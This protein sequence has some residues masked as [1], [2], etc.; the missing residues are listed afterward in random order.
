MSRNILPSALNY[1]ANTSRVRIAHLVILELPS[2]TEEQPVYDYLTDY[3]TEVKHNNHVYAPDRVVKVG[4]VR[5]GLK[6]TNYK[7][8]VSIAGEYQDELNRA[9]NEN[10]ESSFVGKT[11]RVLRAYLDDEGKVIPFD[12][13]TLGP[14]EYFFGNVSDIAIADGVV[15]GSSTVTWQCAGKFEDFNL[16]NG[17]L[18]DDASH[19]GLETVPGTSELAP[20]TGA[21]KPEYMLD[22]GFQHANQTISLLSTYTT[23]EIRYKMK[24]SFFGL[25]SKLQEVEVQVEKELEL[26]VDLEAKYLPF[27][28][29]VRR[30]PGMPIFIDNLAHDPAKLIIVYSIA[31]GPAS[32]LNLFIGGESAICVD[33]AQQETDMCLGSQA[34]GDTLS[35]FLRQDSGY[36]N[37]N[38]SYSPSL[39]ETERQVAVA[40]MPTVS[41]IFPTSNTTP[42]SKGI[43]RSGTKFTITNSTGVKKFTYYTG[44]P[45]QLAD[46][47]MVSIAANRAF[48]RQRKENLGPEYWDASSKLLDTAYLI[49]E[50][51]ISEG[52]QEIPELEMVIESH[53]TDGNNPVISLNPADHLQ[54]YLASKAFGGGLSPSE[55][56]FAS[57]DY[58][59]SVLGSELKSYDKNWNK[60]WRYLGWQSLEDHTPTLLECNSYISTEDT[61]TKN[62]ESFLAQMDATLNQ[63]GGKYHLSIEDG[64]DPIADILIEEVIGSV[65]VKD[66]SGKDK[67]NSIS[68]NLIDPALN[69]SANKLVFFDSEYLEQDK[70]VQ[71]KGTVSFNHITN[72]YVARNWAR[73]Q[74]DRSRYSREVTI[75]TYH[76]YTY[77]YP[78]AN[79]TFTYPRFGWDKKKLRVK[80]TTLKADGTIGL[81][82]VDTDASIYEDIVDT[83]LPDNP[84]VGTGIVPPQN[85]QFI[86]TSDENFDIKAEDNV[87]GFL[88]WSP[89]AGSSI[90]RYEVEDW[91]RPDHYEYNVVVPYNKIVYHKTSG[92]PFIFQEITDINLGTGYTFRVRTLDRSGKYSKYS[93]LD[94]TFSNNDLPGSYSKVTNFIA[95]NISDTG[96]YSGDTVY[97]Q[98]DKHPSPEITHYHLELLD[99]ASLGVF[100]IL[101]EEVSFTFDIQKNMSL[102]ANNN[103]GL[104]GAYRDYTARIRAVAI[105]GESDWQYL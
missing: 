81:T 92:E 61:V 11:V 88:L 5:Q 40:S 29:G 37:L 82:L 75:T 6:L 86:T 101:S 80:G 7:L 20:G 46:P 105:N 42:A 35:K 38:S 68:A 99:G 31:E 43:S 24:S 57:F 10:K 100:T 87:Y 71:K 63:L 47:T 32:L 51:Q 62:V 44:S 66:V 33:E 98:W 59:R 83:K 52:E 27:V 67:W 2:S 23:K 17:R 45:G 18:T 94:K 79:V 104:V 34:N 78:N 28:R 48:F 26:G 64:A 58:V 54:E 85:L 39:R 95:T 65:G 14:M 3:A 103:T 73:R 19:R 89:Y 16:V 96:I 50:M 13:T 9:L 69:W 22:T 56:D 30:V 74:L 15:S 49:L 12:K 1:L 21:K 25:K 8:S 60:L 90:L 55:I 72:Y 97:M 76:K 41:P 93:L 53:P 4:D 70:G 77:L 91:N 102:F 84:V 36:R